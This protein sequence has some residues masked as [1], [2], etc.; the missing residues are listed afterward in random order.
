MK[1]VQ[2]WGSVEEDIFGN[3][4]CPTNRESLG[5]AAE[6]AVV[7]VSDL[8]ETLQM[9]KRGEALVNQVTKVVTAILDALEI[10]PHEFVGEFSKT[11]DFRVRH[12]RTMAEGT[13]E[14]KVYSDLNAR[15]CPNVCGQGNRGFLKEVVSAI[16]PPPDKMTEDFFKTFVFENQCHVVNTMWKMMFKDE[17]LGIAAKTQSGFSYYAIHGSKARDLN[18]SSSSLALNHNDRTWGGVMSVDIVHNGSLRLAHCQWV[19]NGINFRFYLPGMLQ[20]IKP[21]IVK[22]GHCDCG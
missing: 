11:S 8:P 19:R 22:C 17:N 21:A 2:K 4:V 20:L 14:L 18:F 9:A 15:V 10:T 5:R 7:R 12:N 1:L 3:A 16:Q 13:F 6:L